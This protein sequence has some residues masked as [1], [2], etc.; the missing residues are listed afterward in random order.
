MMISY[1]GPTAVLLKAGKESPGGGGGE[2][3]RPFV[4]I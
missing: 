1:A 2:P 4:A 3:L